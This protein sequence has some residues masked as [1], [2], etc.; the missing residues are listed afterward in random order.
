[1]T[2]P[3]DLVKEG[4]QLFGGLCISRGVWVFVVV[5]LGYDSSV[6]EEG[7]DVAFL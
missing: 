7:G 4:F 5:E 2:L 3:V 1:M 6:E